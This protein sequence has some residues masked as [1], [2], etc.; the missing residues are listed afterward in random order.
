MTVEWNVTKAV[1]VG[2]STLRKQSVRRE[3]GDCRME[4]YQGCG[5]WQVH[6]EEAVSTERER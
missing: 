2:R 6:P 3:R 4:C 1:A 5:C